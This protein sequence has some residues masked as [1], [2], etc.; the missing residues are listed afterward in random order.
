MSN[1]AF[2]DLRDA[3]QSPAADTAHGSI[4]APRRGPDTRPDAGTVLDGEL[5]LSGYLAAVARQLDRRGIGVRHQHTRGGDTARL[6]GLLALAPEP[7]AG[8]SRWAPVE[9]RW[10][11]DRGWSATLLPTDREAW[12]RCPH[13]VQRYLPRTLVPAPDTV[14]HFVAAL[15]ADEHTIWACATFRPP[16]RADRRWLVLQLSRFAQPEPWQPPVQ[17]G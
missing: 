5:L 6:S 14:A 8:G 15:N 3:D 1:S 13:G 17:R 4:P 2:R 9:L 10:Q 12:R 16:R 7:R 11:Q